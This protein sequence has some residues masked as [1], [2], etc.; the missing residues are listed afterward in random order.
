MYLRGLYSVYVYDIPVPGP[1]IGLGE[2]PQKIEKNLS[3]GKKEETFRRATEEDPSPGWREARGVMW[4]DEQRYN[5]FKEYDRNVWITGSSSADSLSSC[6]FKRFALKAKL[7]VI[8]LTIWSSFQSHPL[9]FIKLST[10][11]RRSKHNSLYFE[12]DDE[13]SKTSEWLP[14]ETHEI[15]D[16]NAF[17][18]K[19]LPK[20]LFWITFVSRPQRHLFFLLGYPKADNR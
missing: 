13:Q 6:L 19:Y 12:Q 11:P 8:P 14:E 15:D 1:H 3:C 16:W 10:L 20:F 9:L 7:K 5:T 17:L 18:E 2:I 4:P